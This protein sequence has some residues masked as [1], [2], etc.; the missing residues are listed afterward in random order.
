MAECPI[1]LSADRF[2]CEK[3]GGG[4]ADGT[5]YDCDVCGA[6]MVT[7]SAE[8]GSLHRDSADFP[9]ILR[10]VLSHRTRLKTESLA[11]SDNV[12]IIDSTLVSNL[13]EEQPRLPSPGQQMIAALRYVGEQVLS[14][15]QPIDNLSPSFQAL[16]GAPNRRFSD[17]M[18][19]G[20]GDRGLL[21][22][23]SAEDHENPE[24][25]IYVDLTPQGWELFEDERKGK[26]S[27]SYGFIALK[28]NDPILDA[29]LANHIKPRLAD[30]GFPLIDLRDVSKAG[31][32]DNLLR[33][34]IKDSKFV[35]VD[36][37]HDNS[38]AYWEAGYAEGLGKPVI[39]ICERGK[40]A[41]KATHF[42]TNHC[43][44]VLWDADQVDHFLEELVATIRRSFEI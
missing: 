25:I 30:F 20:L 8:V 1:C 31:V 33:S 11:N 32:I 35:L 2:P 3:W 13:I 24:A 9:L 23:I 26:L 27:S 41:E 36:L 22:F 39:Y 10:A 42:D 4:R 34:Q 16:I 29:L 43:T 21:T 12:P 28:F 18:V 15:F 14:T 44:T 17:K 37:T 40:F 7:R 19:R 38:G 6:F 5:R